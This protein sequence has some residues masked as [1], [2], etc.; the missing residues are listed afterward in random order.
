MLTRK[1]SG[2]VARPESLAA[3]FSRRFSNRRLRSASR[4]FCF[5]SSF[6]LLRRAF[7]S[8]ILHASSG[9][10]LVRPISLYLLAALMDKCKHCLHSL[11]NVY[12][13]P[14]L[15]PLFISLCKQ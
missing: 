15:Y 4:I 11:N 14:L 12:I 5:T 1:D 13:C 10:S 8:L 6:Y 7:L 9:G 3:T 2:L